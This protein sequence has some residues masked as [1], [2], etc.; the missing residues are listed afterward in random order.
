MIP[1]R[2]DIWDSLFHGCAWAAYLDQA[3]EER[4]WPSREATRRRA[5]QYYEEALAAKNAAKSHPY[6]KPPSVNNQNGKDNN[7]ITEDYLDR[8]LE[9]MAKDLDAF[10]KKYKLPNESA[11]ELILRR[12][13]TVKQ[14]SWLYDFIE[15]WYAV[16]YQYQLLPSKK[17]NHA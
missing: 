3:A 8:E 15:R 12:G 14:S 7:M 6:P 17:T 9:T 10:C 13:L 1:A 11:D 5:Y 2:D 4:G 16:E